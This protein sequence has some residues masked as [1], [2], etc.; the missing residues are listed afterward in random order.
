MS[1]IAAHLSAVILGCLVTTPVFAAELH[2]DGPFAADSSEARLIETFGKNN[3]VTGEVPGPE[4]STVIATTVFPNDPEKK[5]E[6]G[7]WDEERFERL[8]YFTVPAGDTA[9]NG[10][11]VG[12]TVKE[13]E[14]LN[15][16][17]FTLSG[18][19]W[20]YGGFAS[21]EGSNLGDI[22]GGCSVS[23]QF[24]PTADIPGDV[25][26]EAISGDHQVDS[27]EPLLETV[28]ASI[29]T[30]TVGYRDYSSMED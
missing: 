2:C 7:W 20:D 21:F 12:M 13:V 16:G 3:V 11:R 24:Q 9:P 10:L 26:V 22:E 25:D 29:D 23:V 27:T 4:G 18:F 30:I 6:F 1:R 5:M 17:P 19:W 14:A 15:G 8:A 28:D